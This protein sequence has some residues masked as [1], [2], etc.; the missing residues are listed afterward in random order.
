MAQT[1]T[2]GKVLK[3]TTLVVSEDKMVGTILLT[4]APT[5]ATFEVSKA[6]WH[7]RTAVAYLTLG[8][9]TDAIKLCGAQCAAQNDRLGYLA[10][11]GENDL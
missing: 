10:T 4:I 2:R 7:E 8:K 6:S 3:A 5:R 1:T 9:R 11:V